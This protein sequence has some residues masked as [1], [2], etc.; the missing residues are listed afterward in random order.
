MFIYVSHFSSLFPQISSSLCLVSKKAPLITF[1][2]IVH[3]SFEV[4]NVCEINCGY[5]SNA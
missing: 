4:S 3:C 2:I 5:K 1:T